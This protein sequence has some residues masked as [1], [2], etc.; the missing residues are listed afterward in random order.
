MLVFQAYA[1]FYYE[2][3]KFFVSGFRSKWLRGVLDRLSTRHAPPFWFR[4]FTSTCFSKRCY[5][6]L[7]RTRPVDVGLP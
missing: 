7:S 1:V 2:G 6:Q 3:V 5:G 4:P